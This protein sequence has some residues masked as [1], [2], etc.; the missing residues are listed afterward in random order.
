MQRSR[1]MVFILSA[2]AGTGKTTLVDRLCEELPR[3]KRSTSCTTRQP[4]TGEIPDVSYRFISSEEFRRLEECSAFLEC[5]Q[6]FGNLYGTLR[7]DVESVLEKG[8]HIILV[9]D[10]QGALQ[11]FDQINATTIFVRPPSLEALRERLERR[12]TDTSEEIAMRLAWAQ[13][14][15]E[16]A[17]HYDY[18]VCNDEFEQALD[19]LRSIVIAEEHRNQR[20][21]IVRD[22]HGAG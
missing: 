3:M 20:L 22:G 12:G 8:D 11:L 17:R 6:L 13:H 15:I 9:I 21:K 19:V 16:L 1:G 4:R 7:N 14:E 5:A 18:I 2:P 10:T